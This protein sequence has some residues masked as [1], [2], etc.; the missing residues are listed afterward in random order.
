MLETAAIVKRLPR[1]LQL[2]FSVASLLMAFGPANAE[3]KPDRPVRILVPFAPGGAS[4]TMV[5]LVAAEASKSIGQQIVIENKP[6]ASGKILYEYLK[7]QAPDGHTLGYMSTTGAVLSAVSS[8][9]DFDVVKDFV[10]I[11]VLAEFTSVLAASSAVPAK[12][13]RELVAYAKANPGK[14]AYAS[15]G[16]KGQGHLTMEQVKLAAGVEFTHIPFRGEAPTLQ[17]LLRNDVQIGPVILST[18][19]YVDAGQLKILAAFGNTRSEEYP[20]VPTLIEQGFPVSSKTWMGMS[21]PPGMSKEVAAFW[22][23][24]LVAAVQKPLVV[25]RLKELGLRARG[26]PPDEVTRELK[27]DID[28]YSTVVASA[29]IELD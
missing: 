12:D 3:W 6:G 15:Y 21:G 13:F 26:T 29:K 14:I 4:D 2:T 22:N 7:T 5:R 24:T 9:L 16:A 23:R 18:K 11:T 28:L 25:Q 19:Q 10:P 8:K 27:G 1:L 20:D 17:A